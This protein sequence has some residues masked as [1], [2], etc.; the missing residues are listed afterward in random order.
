MSLPTVLVTGA[1][2]R[3]GTAVCATLLERGFSVRATDRRFTKDFPIRVEVGD[4]CD[5]YF[6]HRV[7]EGVDAVVHLANHPNPFS[8]PTPQRLLAD[9]VAMNGNVFHAAVSLGVRSLVFASSI[10]VMIRRDRPVKAP[11]F[12]IPYLPL[13]GELP[14]NPGLNTYG[15]SKE[16]GERLLR[17]YT[18]SDPA[19][20]ATSIR[21]PMLVG[22]WHLSRMQMGKP[23]PLASIDFIEATAHLFLE[24]AG[25]LVAAVLER[26]L[27][28][29]HQYFPARS[30]ELRGYSLEEILRDRYPDV[31]RRGAL[32][33][34]DGLIDLSAITREVGW[35][36]VH[37]LVY[38]VER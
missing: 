26:R 28:G 10:Q 37:R 27:P 14:P 17:L 30:M 24:D 2:G 35:V 3:L 13:D 29:Y 9:N 7:V 23:L 1:T 4:V 38:D 8:G 6:A 15:I 33:A 22:D 19:L 5:E 16:F 21:F 20:S 12:P 32:P 18:E 31:P 25:T 36:P 11:P 34:D